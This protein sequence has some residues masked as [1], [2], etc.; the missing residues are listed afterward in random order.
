MGMF[1]RMN[2]SF[3]MGPFET[4]NTHI[5][6]FHIGV[7]PGEDTSDELILKPHPCKGHNILL[8]M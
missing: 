6:A 8:L 4:S 5:E 3:K 7:A 1:F 2:L